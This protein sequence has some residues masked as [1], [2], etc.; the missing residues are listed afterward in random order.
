MYPKTL[1]V[2]LLFCLSSAICPAQ[3]K[4]YDLSTPTDLPQ[5]GVNKLLCMKNGNTMLFH[6]DQ[7]KP[8]TVKVYES[9]HKEIASEKISCRILDIYILKD[10]I[11]KGLWEVNGEAVLFMQQEHLSR[12]GLVRLRFN[13]NAKLVDETLVRNSRSFTR[14]TYFYV[15]KNKDEDNYSILYCEDV[16]Q[17]KECKMDIVQYS[18]NHDIISDI[19]LEIDRKKYDDL[20]VTGAEATSAGTCV[21][22]TLSNLQTNQTMSYQGEFDRPPAIY[23]RFLAV[24][25]IAP[26]STKPILKM[27]HLGTNVFPLHDYCTYNPVAQTFNLFLCSYNDVLYRFGGEL[28]PS[29]YTSDL[30]FTMNKDEPVM[31]FKWIDNNMASSYM[32][33]HAAIGAPFQGVP[34]YLSTNRN[35]LSTSVFESF[36][37]YDNLESYLHPHLYETYLENIAITQFDDDGNEIWG[38]VL[39]KTQYYKSY[40]HYYYVDH[41]SKSWQQDRL[42]GD[43][44]PEVYARQF[45][46]L[47]TYIHANNLY[48][49]Y[50]DVNKNFN[51]TITHPGDTMYACTNTNTCYYKINKQKEVTKNYLF[52]EPATDEYKASFIEG[53]DFDEQRGVYAALVQYKKG[54]DIS[55]C[56]AWSRLD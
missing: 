27:A 15:T 10:V 23:D 9:L 50:N 22:I 51:N 25:Y 38:V 52:G 26:G 12:T 34:V 41:L 7:D 40:F 29:I 48:V 37:R 30:L 43:N 8:I 18:K 3:D 55:L 19:P 42:F 21:T 33:E 28:R 17:M 14:R 53:A 4:K 20:Q 36:Y 35:G 39:P 54:D 2:L 6:F 13:S 46:S 32:K 24:Y 44:P 31:N 5:T 11:F 45:V 47:N 56:M 16:A 49:V 1:F